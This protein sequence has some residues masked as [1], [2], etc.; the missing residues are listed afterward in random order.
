MRISKIYFAS[1]LIACGI[2]Y[3]CEDRELLPNVC[4]NCE[5]EA[6]LDSI[7]WEAHVTSCYFYEDGFINDDPT[8][9]III[10]EDNPLD[11][12]ADHL[13]FTDLPAFPGHYNVRWNT[14]IFIHNP[15]ASFQSMRKGFQF[16][17]Y[18]PNDTLES[19]VNVESIDPVTGEWRINFSLSLKF[20]KPDYV[21]QEDTLYPRNFSITNGFAK[22]TFPE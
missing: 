12:E 22:G 16:E 7:P 1:I 10:K 11:G 3:A 13:A 15:S 2:I 6:I 18:V 9:S 20:N 19:F 4:L 8:F 17:N 14:E 21:A 5:F